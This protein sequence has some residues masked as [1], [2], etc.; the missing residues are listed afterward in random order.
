MSRTFGLST[1]AEIEAPCSAARGAI[2]GRA[3]AIADVVGEDDDDVGMFSGAPAAWQPVRTTS[4]VGD[5]QR[6]EFIIGVWPAEALRQTKP[7]SA[8]STARRGAGG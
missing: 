8:R 6:P 7:K 4:N 2:G 5:R 1:A 3:F